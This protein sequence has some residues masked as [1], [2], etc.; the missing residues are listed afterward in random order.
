M[1][2]KY[3]NIQLEIVLHLLSKRENHIRAIAQDLNTTHTTILR[4]IH[5][6]IKQNVL[7]V[8]K[9]GKNKIAFLKKTMAT[10]QYVY[11]AEHYKTEKILHKYPQLSVM[12]KEVLTETDAPLIVLFGSYAKER[13]KQD[14]D[15]DVFIET[16]ERKLKEKIKHI[17]RKINP[18]FGAFDVD[19]VLIKEIIKN[20]AIIRGVEHFYERIKFFD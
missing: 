3:S 8:K 19:N 5:Y 6:L 1:V 11:M 13:A 14:S 16:K 20:H 12:M 7:D 9:Q 2:Q 18:K 17:N 10:R 15:I 4:K